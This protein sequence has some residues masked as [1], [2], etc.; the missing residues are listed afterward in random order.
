MA[1]VRAA[2]LRDFAAPVS[3]PRP[4][5]HGSQREDAVIA[6]F[7][8]PYG[9]TREASAVAKE[10]FLPGVAAVAEGNGRGRGATAVDA[11]RVN[12]HR[13][14]GGDFAGLKCPAEKKT[15]GYSTSVELFKG[16]LATG[17]AL[18]DAV[19]AN[20]RNRKA[21]PV[22][23]VHTTGSLE[24]PA[25]AGW[26]IRDFGAILT[27]CTNAEDWPLWAG[28]PRKPVNDRHR[29]AG[30]SPASVWVTLLRRDLLGYDAK[31]N[32]QVRYTPDDAGT[33]VA[34][35][36]TFSQRSGAVFRTGTP[37]QFAADLDAA[38]VR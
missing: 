5:W 36:A 10:S 31:G 32:P 22:A 25:I 3:D 1:K 27:A 28:I 30:G 20:H 16:T 18:A 34:I 35:N 19:R 9:W 26:C 6:A 37:A 24:A 2:D 23:V 38:T 8:A 33:Y 12:P 13:A 21:F 15:G 29:G 14:S 7:L 4:S 11:F 17:S